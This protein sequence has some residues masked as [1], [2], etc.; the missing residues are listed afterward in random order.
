MEL[1]PAYGD[2]EKCTTVYD[3][4]VDQVIARGCLS[5]LTTQQK[6]M[7]DQNSPNCQKCAYNFCNKDDSKLKI[8][9]CVGCNSEDDSNCA[10]ENL[11]TKDKRCLTD[12]CFSRLI[13]R[14]DKHFGQL[15]ERGCMADLLQ[16]T[17]CLEPDCVG[18]LVFLLSHLVYFFLVF[19]SII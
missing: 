10:K 3:P 17:E 8:N 6:E 12:Q 16:S 9:F 14:D 4:D 19:G 15:M 2:M 13:E 7:C 11:M 1:C 18:W 5:T